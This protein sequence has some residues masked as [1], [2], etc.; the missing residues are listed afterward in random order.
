[1]SAEGLNITKVPLGVVVS[2]MFEFII[3][4]I[5]SSSRLSKEISLLDLAR[6]KGKASW[7]KLGSGMK[8]RLY[9]SV[10]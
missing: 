7:S 10:G 9:A 6:I 5:V 4:S 2:T 3:I 1:M 8:L